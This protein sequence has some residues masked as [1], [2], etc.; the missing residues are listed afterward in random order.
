METRWMRQVIGVGGWTVFRKASVLPH[1]AEGEGPDV[2]IPPCSGRQERWSVAVSI[3]VLGSVVVKA[4]PFLFSEDA[5]SSNPLCHMTTITLTR[6]SI[7]Y[8][9]KDH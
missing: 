9:K 4:I 8:C 2:S 5:D 3:P 1:H 7:R 6:F